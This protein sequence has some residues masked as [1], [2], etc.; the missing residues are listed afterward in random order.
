MSYIEPNST[1]KV[2]HNV[3]LDKTYDHTLFFALNNQASQTNYFLSMTKYTFERQSYQRVNKNVLRIE[4]LADLLYDCNYM[5]FKNDR[6]GLQ[7]RWFY[8]FINTVTYIN[9]NV[10]EIEYEIDVMQTWHYNYMLDYCF[11]EREHA[12]TDV[13]GDN[14]VPENLEL[15]EYQTG[16]ASFPT[17]MINGVSTN[18]LAQKSIVIATSYDADGDVDHP[19]YAWFYGNLFSGLKLTAFSNDQ[20]GIDDAKAFIKDANDNL[21]TDGIISMFYAPTNFVTDSG[22]PVK[23]Y[24]CTFT[25]Q[26]T[27]FDGYVP[28]NKK[29]FTYPYNFLYVTNMQGKSAVFPYEFFSTSNCVFLLYGDFNLN[30]SVLLFPCYYK[31]ANTN[32]D[33][34]L[35]ISGWPMCSWTTDVFQAWVAQEAA[36][37]PFSAMQ[38]VVSSAS[39]L[40]TAGMMSQV[41]GSDMPLLMS[42]QGV[43]ANIAG[44]V[45]NVCKEAAIHAL[46]PPQSHGTQSGS[47]L[48]S[49]NLLNFAFYNKHIRSDFA[50]MIDQYFDMYGYA[51]HRVKVPNRSVRDEWTYTK[52]VGCT[53][54]GAMPSDDQRKICDIYNNGITFW[55]N[56]SHVGNYSLPNPIST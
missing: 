45:F 51:T 14:L 46:Q 19:E 23:Q 42:K 27:S 4:K 26:T 2:L 47:T 52:T 20:Q 36:A 48:A 34:L 1:I 28:H 54:I 44:Q 35:Q 5:M 7:E 12:A 24:T 17:A 16:E 50:Q 29:L 38:T 18:V 40:T 11:V 55:K 10:A 15:G 53:I 21:K 9:E 41:M 31:G 22:D 13:I 56:P 37:L 33:E 30:P 43:T 6:T 32:Y 49:A 3:P 8:A 25:K 39:S